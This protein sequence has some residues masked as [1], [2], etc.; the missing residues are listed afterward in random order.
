MVIYTSENNKAFHLIF[1]LFK[2][3][4]NNMTLVNYNE[5]KNSFKRHIRLIYFILEHLDFWISIY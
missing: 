3:S 5:N 1:I 2:S 4:L